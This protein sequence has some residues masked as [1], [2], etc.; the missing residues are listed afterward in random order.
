MQ[1]LHMLVAAVLKSQ[2]NWKIRLM[3]DWVAIV[4]NMSQ[5][6]CLEKIADDATLVI[7]VHDT[8]WMQQL[9]YLSYELIDL[10]NRGLGSAYVTTVRFVLSRRLQ[11]S[12]K[13]RRKTSAPPVSTKKTAQP[14]RALNNKQMGA[15]QNIAD[16]E[17]QDCLRD[18]IQMSA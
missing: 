16:R 15:L 9:H 7:G 2:D 13:V 17:L 10:I 11:V 6:I 5:H 4:G 8:K 18:L 1:S 3:V 14:R 12:Y